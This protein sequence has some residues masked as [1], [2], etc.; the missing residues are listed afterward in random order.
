MRVAMMLADHAVVAGGKLYVNGGGWS[1]RSAA[2]LETYIPLKL[3]VPWDQTD[4]TME[5]SLR[6]VDEDG[7]PVRVGVGPAPDWAAPDASG[8]PGR[9][10]AGEALPAPLQL[11]TRITVQRPPG[12]VPGAPADALLAFRVPPFPLPAGCRFSWRLAIDGQEHEDWVLQFATST[13]SPGS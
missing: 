8:R 6:L 10:P 3:D 5:I 7:H 4:Q 11:T 13:A 9:P 1:I 2:P 12:L